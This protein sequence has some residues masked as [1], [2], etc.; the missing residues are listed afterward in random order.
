[1]YKYTDEQLRDAVSDSNSF[2]RVLATLSMQKSGAAVTVLKRRIDELSLDT[3][4][5]YSS[6]GQ[7]RGIKRETDEYLVANGPEI[8]SHDLKKRLFSEGRLDARCSD[9][10]ITHWNGHTNIF[11]L[12]HIN[13]DRRDNRIEN[14]RILCANCHRTTETWGRKK[15]TTMSTLLGGE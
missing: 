3:S 10:E 5:F 8:G 11:D 12:D 1:M 14:L 2:S 13:G 7:Q 6:K 4:H 9:C 15:R